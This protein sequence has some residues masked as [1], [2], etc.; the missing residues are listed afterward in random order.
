MD[1]CLTSCKGSQKEQE[2]H[3]AGMRL[4]PYTGN[5]LLVIKE[6][7]G[8][9]IENNT[10]RRIFPA[11]RSA[12]DLSMRVGLQ[13]ELVNTSNGIPEGRLRGMNGNDN[14]PGQAIKKTDSLKAENEK[15]TAGYKL[16]CLATQLDLNSHTE[17]DAAS[18]CKQLDLNG[19]S[20]N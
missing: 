16:P 1:S 15:M 7:A 17:I 6:T 20:W 10:E 9:H 12:G 19:F 14:F 13:V 5:A 11:E 18:S 4:W 2:M 8:E 3:T